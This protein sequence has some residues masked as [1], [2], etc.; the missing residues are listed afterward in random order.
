MSFANAKWDLINKDIEESSKE[1]AKALGLSPLLIQICR[2]RGYQTEEQIQEFLSSSP[3]LWHDPYLMYDMEKAIQRIQQAIETDES[4]LIFGD[5]DA[6]GITSTAVLYETLEMM[7]AQVEYYLPNRFIDGYGPNIRVFEEYL[8]KGVSLIITVDCGIAAHESVEWA[9]SQ[10][11]DVI[12]TDH[13]EIPP[14]LPKAYAVI[15]PRHPDGEYP[16][17]DL[18]GAGVAFKLAHALLGELPV[19]LAEIACIGTIADLVSLTDENRS[20]VKL[21]LQQLNQTERIG[22]S[23]LFQELQL[24]PGS[25]DEKTIGFQVGPCLNALGRLGDAT[26]GVS[27]FTTFDDEVAQEVV[28]LMQQENAKRKQI[29]D[30]ITKEAL[31]L[32][33]AQIDH[34]VLVLAQSNWHE[35][36]LGIVASRIV[37]QL[38]KPTIVLGIQSDGLMAKG[39]ARSCA[40]FNLYDA[41]SSCQ[42]SLA[43][44]G[45]HHMAAGLS[46]ETVMLPG[47]MEAIETYAKQHPELLEDE[48]VISIEEALSLSQVNVEF[49]DSLQALKPYGTNNAEPIFKIS[50]ISVS[51]K[52]KIGAQQQHLKLTLNSEQQQ[53]QAL[54]FNKGEWA[55]S[56]NLQA[57]V[58]VIGT[59]EINEWQ[60]N[61]LPQLMLKDI[62]VKDALIF[63]WRTNKIR[64]DHLSV[65]KAA[66]L[67]E[68][69]TLK[70]IVSERI[71]T[72]SKVFSMEEWIKEEKQAD[73]DSIV[74]FDCPKS[75]EVIQEFRKHSYTQKMYI[76][77]YTQKSIM[78]MGIPTRERFV[79]VYQYLKTHSNVPYN[80]KT[81]EL[82]NYLKI[83]LDQF[84]VI[85]KVFFELKFVI[86]ENGCLRLNPESTSM[87]LMQSNLMKQLQEELWLERVFIYSQFSDLT[88]WLTNMEEEK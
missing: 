80:E 68:R 38:Q 37:E 28:T 26:P 10:Q 17:G 56:L 40:Q 1:I 12:V 4:I 60:Q 18:S 34:K 82:A 7:G 83:P 61:R 63:D 13:H 49:I 85:L 5:Y 42:E 2:R 41:L 72:T 50:N 71:D 86:I 44:F 30:D 45:G 29:V 47:F 36:V 3:T 8:E 55:D 51:Q 57:E 14:V 77:A 31:E 74:L 48:K 23:Y 75:K 46:V 39:S 25:I 19:E 43:K 52:Q 15:H 53:L 64:P 73:F 20:L 88:N 62:A 33:K 78:T 59:L 70:P 65:K 66:Y 58:E 24:T 6:D 16:F 22:L 32:A 35:G 9:M 69:D 84:K 11:C 79:A 27:L 87:D 81:G 54:M 76:I 67:V 21:G